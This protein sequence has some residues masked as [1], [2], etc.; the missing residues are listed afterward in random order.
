[1]HGKVASNWTVSVLAKLC[2]VSRSTFAHRFR[3]TVGMGPIE[4][5]QRWRMA[6]AKD[7]LIRGKRSVG[8]IALAIGFQSS[9]AFST[10][11][12]RA[13]GCSPKQFATSKSR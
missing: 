13:M 12:S 11:F 10:A 3:V 2:G 1:M 4:Y 5:L 8:E 9:S 6:L 7:D